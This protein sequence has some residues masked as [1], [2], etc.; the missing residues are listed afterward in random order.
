MTRG[1]KVVLCAVEGWGKTSIAAR[2][3][4]PVMLLAPFETGYLTLHTRGLV[5]EVPHFTMRGWDETIKTIEAIA[6]NPKGARTVVL[7]A[8]A[9]YES[10][11]AEYVREVHH[12]GSLS[13][14]NAFGRGAAN[15][16]REWPSL[17][18]ALEACVEHGLNVCV[19]AHTQVK[20]FKNPEGPDYDRYTVNVGDEVWQRTKMWAEAVVFGTWRAIVDGRRSGTGKAIGQ[21][22][23]LRCQYSPLVDAKN[24]YGL[25]PEYAVPE[26]SD[27]AARA[28][29]ELIRGRQP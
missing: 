9:G 22:R 8:L 10:L 29:W 2:A 23:I 27:V 20:N 17:L 3:E 19:C 24:Q 21:L 14:F 12:K 25:L 15:M 28:F 13:D 7:D 11:C 5:P 18:A 6:E 1:F 4:R 16:R 26:G